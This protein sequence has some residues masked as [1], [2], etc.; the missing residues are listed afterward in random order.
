MN[1]VRFRPLTS[2]SDT[3]IYAPTIN[4]FV[5]TEGPHAGDTVSR[6]TFMCVMYSALDPHKPFG[7][8]VYVNLENSKPIVKMDYGIDCDLTT[9]FVDK[10]YSLNSVPVDHDSTRWVIFADTAGT[11]PLAV[12]WG[13]SVSYRFAAE[14]R[15][16]V[17]LRT[18]LQGMNCGS[19]KELICN[20]V[21][22]HEVPIGL[23]E[24]RLCDGDTCVAWAIGGEGLDKEWHVDDSLLYHFSAS[25]PF[26]TIRWIPTIGMHTVSLTTTVGGLC[27]YTTTTTFRV[28][29][30]DTI[31]TD[32]TDLHICQ[33]D[34]VTLS[35][36]GIEFPLWT[37]EPFDSSIEGF[38]NSHVVTVAPQVTTTYTVHPTGD[39]RC[40]QSPASITLNVAPNPVPNVWIDR[41]TLEFTSPSIHV[42]DHS[43][44]ST[45]SHWIF[46][47]GQT[48][49]GTVVNHTFD[50]IGDSVTVTLHTCNEVTC[51]AD[52]TVVIPIKINLLWIPNTFTPGSE[53]NNRFTFVTSHEI[54]FYEIWIYNRQGLLVYHGTDINQPWDG[55]DLNGN[56]SP[57]GA[58]VYHYVYSCTQDSARRHTG[59]GTVT[60]L[61]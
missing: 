37:A 24:D 8:R 11:Q 53:T 30:D 15:Y 13:D 25:Q 6:Q 49:D 44:Y 5:L 23:A 2:L 22:P 18:K 56:P 27:P 51:C 31:S 28:N 26:D 40:P 61:R 42:E 29:G 16:R 12:L 47:D 38:E 58:Y 17:E 36:R 48:A 19:I 46:S 3:N 10:S 43:L 55:T 45:S 39:I 34:S 7:S 14:G 50:L 35:I 21:Q 4:D 57:Q 54:T 41:K 52:T 33:G 59:N 1:D 60:L 9:Y 32:A 20:V